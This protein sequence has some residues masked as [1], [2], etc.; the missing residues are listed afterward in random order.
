[1][2]SAHIYPFPR[3]FRRRPTPPAPFYAASW[4]SPFHSGG[5][6]LLWAA[7][8]VAA[9]LYLFGA[10]GLARHDTLYALLL[11][12]VWGLYFFHVPLLRTR[13][14]P[15]LRRGGQLLLIASAVGFFGGIYWLILTHD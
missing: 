2:P 14:G 9:F 4:R 13:I 3:A 6:A 15:L 11:A 5:F 1:M 12:T 7:T 8:L 10:A